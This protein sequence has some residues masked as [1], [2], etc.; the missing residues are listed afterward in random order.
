VFAAGI[1]LLLGLIYIQTASYLNRRVD[2]ILQFEANFLESRGPEHIGRFIDQELARDALTRIG[3]YSAD[4]TLIAGST[5]VQL[6]DSRLDGRPRD[7]L[8]RS[9]A[10][11]SR[12]LARRTAWGEIL[13]VERDT[14][15]VTALRGI[16]L[17]ALL[18]SGAAIALLGLIT[19]VMLSLRPL[20]RITAMRKAS[21]AIG[22]GNFAVRLPT[23]GSHDELDDLAEIVNRM[24]DE[25]ERL[26][27]QARTVGQ[28]VAHELRSPLTR[29][30]TLLDQACESLPADDPRH[31]LLERC[32]AEADTVLSRFQ[33]LLRIAALE[34]RGRRTGFAIVS[35]SEMA[36]QIIEL[37]EPL[38]VDLGI[39]LTIESDHGVT[40]RG[41]RELLF[42]ALSNLVDNALKFTGAGG[43]VSVRAWRTPTGACVEVRDDG[44]GIPQAERSFVTRRFY[45]G[46]AQMGVEGHGLGLSLVAAVADLHGFQ[47]SIGDAHPGAI[48]Q[49]RCDETGLAG[50]SS[51]PPP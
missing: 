36:C 22:M 12:A 15:Q 17:S 14:R 44:P 16:I 31:G 6:S 10:G 11:P 5:D 2:R 45:R 49:L 3:L 37:Y 24:M 7:T 18:W 19:A 35:L 1:I 4:G 39:R 33:A 51:G 13:I 34:A 42:E 27:T 38:A 48:I 32:V 43:R 29:L 8:R 30:R 41:D 50:A 21:E 23:T 46:Q 25:A 28:G 47:L 9:G 26:M 20:A 40:V